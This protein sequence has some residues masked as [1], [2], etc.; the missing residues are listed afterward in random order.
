MKKESLEEF[1][2]RGGRIEK[3]NIETRSDAPVFLLR[4]Q[5]PKPSK[6]VLAERRKQ[7]LEK[8][9]K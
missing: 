9:K 8:G 1:L 3:H 5:S 6:E 4:K 7:I 2:S